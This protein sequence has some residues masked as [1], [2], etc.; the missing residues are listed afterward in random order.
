MILL[1]HPTFHEN[2]LELIV[3]LLLENGYPLDFIFMHI[4][5]RANKLINIKLS[6]NPLKDASTQDK[7]EVTKKFFVIPYIKN[8][9]ERVTSLI[10]KNELTVSFRCLEKINNII[11][12]H[13][14]KTDHMCNN[15]VVYKISCNDCDATYVGQ[16]KR[17]LGTRVREHMNNIRL[18]PS[19]HSVVTEHR[20][21]HDHTF[22]WK[23]IKIL[24][25]EPNYKKR[26]VSE[27]IHIKQQN[28]GIN[29]QKDTEFLHDIYFYLLD[30][31]KNK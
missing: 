23:K 27:M 31:V 15:S 25:S 10:D 24:D 30:S 4:G 13:K 29:S 16:T 3:K 9:S 12:V 22:D 18:D 26:L 21:K 7:E 2:N 28:N 8:I 14:D 20:I 6:S 5:T 1:S 19:K 17:Q 11:K